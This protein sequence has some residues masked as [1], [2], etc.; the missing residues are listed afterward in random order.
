L[1]KL[2]F[3]IHCGFSFVVFGFD[4]L[5]FTTIAP[6]VLSFFTVP[7]GRAKTWKIAACQTIKAATLRNGGDYAAAVHLIEHHMLGPG[8]QEALHVRYS[9]AAVRT[10]Q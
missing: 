1:T 7:N 8:S 6:E 2:V 5:P 4:I 3:V 9:S 10:V